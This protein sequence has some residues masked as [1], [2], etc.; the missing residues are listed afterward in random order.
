MTHNIIQIESEHD[1]I[2]RGHVIVIDS[3]TNHIDP[4]IQV[5]DILKTEFSKYEIRGIE[6]MTGS[7]LSGCITKLL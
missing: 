2:G 4:P 3:V 6:R 5:G 1:V 7:T